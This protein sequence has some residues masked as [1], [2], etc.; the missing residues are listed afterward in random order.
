MAVVEEQFVIG[1]RREQYHDLRISVVIPALNEAAN[2]QYVL[3]CL[4]SIVSEVILVDGDS[5]DGTA[6]VAQQLLPSVLII[7]QSGKGKGDALNAGFAACTGDIIVMLDADGSADPGEIPRFID[8]L[9]KGH[10][11]AKGSRFIEDG[12]SHDITWLR[13]LGNYGLS[14]FVNFL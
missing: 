5:T 11:F 7:K 8:A 10:D 12:G 6:T 9:L 3:P 13:R 14:L 4:P 1:K 2:L